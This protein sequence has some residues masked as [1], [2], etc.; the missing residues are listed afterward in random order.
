MRAL[1]LATLLLCHAADAQD[2]FDQ[3]IIHEVRIRSS[4]PA[5]WDSLAK[6]QEAF[7]NGTAAHYRMVDVVVDG[8]FLPNS[9]M[10]FKGDYSYWG[11]PGKKRPIKLDFDRFVNDQEHSWQTKVNLHNFAGDPSF[12]RETLAYGLLREQG[13]PASRTAY[14]QVYMNDTLIGLYLL[15][16]EINKRFC[17][18]RFGNT[19]TLYQCIDN[20]EMAWPGEDTAAYTDEFKVDHDANN[21]GWQ[22]LI[23]LIRLL[24]DDHSAVFR[25]RLDAIF[26]VDQYLH[27]MVLDVL[28][29]NWDSYHDNGRNFSLYHSRRDGRLH[30]IPWDYNLCLW[31]RDLELPPRDNS[32]DGY[33]PLVARIAHDP[34]LME[35]LWRTACT[36]LPQVDLR[37]THDRL[38]AYR[39]LIADAVATDPNKFYSNGAFHNNLYHPVVV[40]MLRGGV[41][42]DV[43]LPGVYDRLV[44]RLAS[45]KLLAQRNTDCSAPVTS[46]LIVNVYP[47]PSMGPV[48]VRW[49]LRGDAVS[50]QLDVHDLLGRPVMTRT[51]SAE[52]ATCEEQLQLAIGQYV[53]R[54]T[55]GRSSQT[56]LLVV[57]GH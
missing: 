10:R 19:G 28:L 27:T 38:V 41:P 11:F 22:P 25:Q 32:A 33:K 56:H 2:I 4:L 13:L 12:L 1:V 5:L 3:R 20:T 44:K 54:I 15:V 17:R 39:A 43:T 7:L 24:H 14:A 16:E 30:W 52:S 46:E 18:S 9:G 29:N 35:D 53:V 6:D 23:D 49:D 50:A 47:N 31:E 37:A 45:L 42:K 55:A 51:Y 26:D 48:T 21:V 8:H 57:A 34:L 36:V 40:T